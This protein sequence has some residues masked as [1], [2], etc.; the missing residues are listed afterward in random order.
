MPIDM[1][2]ISGLAASLQS[3]VEI[4]KAL[5]GV[6]DAVAIQ[7]KV[8][9]LQDAIMAAQSS[10]LEAQA[11]QFRLSSRV[12]ELEEQIAE[13]QDW[14]VEQQQYELK[15]LGH[16]TFAYVPRL[17]TDGS[18]TAYWL[19]QRCF[20]DRRKSVLQYQGQPAKGRGGM[21]GSPR[22]SAEILVRDL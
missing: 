1:G 18:E 5:K 2:S 13:L 6:H 12:R 11:D 4:V 8:I 3:A 7:E 22:C 17:E 21:S 10:A 16:G 19:C 14:D 15:G 20:E 9:E